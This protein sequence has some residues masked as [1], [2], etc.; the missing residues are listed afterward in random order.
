M[1]NFITIPTTVLSALLMVA[2]AAPGADA[3]TVPES[4]QVAAGAELGLF[5]PTDGQFDGALIG[6]G[7]VEVYLT[8]RVSV[9]GSV[10]ATAPAYVRGTEEDERQIRL[11]AD[12]IYNWEMGR[13]HPFAGAGVGL[14]L[15]QLTDEGESV[16]DSET[17]AGLSVLGGLEYFLS[18]RWTLKAEGRYQWV[19]NLPLVN[20]DGF[21][22]TVGLK[23]YF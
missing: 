7:L 10:L 14:H 9:R 4:G 19:A 2:L 5:A 6:G 15:L 11:G 18:R 17:K 12:G 20:P 22:L 13:V 3:Q 1:R 23:R 8:D 21:A 16:G